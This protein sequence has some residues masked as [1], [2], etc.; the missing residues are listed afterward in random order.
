MLCVLFTFKLGM[1]GISGLLSAVYFIQQKTKFFN[2]ICSHGR[3][4]AVV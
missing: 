1:K 4:T 3:D 2:V